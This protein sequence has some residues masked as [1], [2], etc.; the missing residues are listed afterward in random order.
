VPNVCS[1]WCW[2]TRTVHLAQEHIRMV[3]STKVVRRISTESNGTPLMELIMLIGIVV[4][5]V[6]ETHPVWKCY[7]LHLLCLNR[8]LLFFL[9]FSFT[10]QVKESRNY[11]LFYIKPSWNYPYCLFVY[12]FV[13]L[14]V[15]KAATLLLCDY[16]TYDVDFQWFLVNGCFLVF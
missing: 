10:C 14:F 4:F 6:V 16:F 8:A 5:L 3:R 13:C 7:F 11:R 2:I 9:F 15:C 1:Q 12:L